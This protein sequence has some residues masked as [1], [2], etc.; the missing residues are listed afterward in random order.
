MHWW[1][2]AAT[3]TYAM[4]AVGNAYAACILRSR[5][6]WCPSAAGFALIA[7]MSAVY[8]AAWGWVAVDPSVDR[9]G[10]SEFITPGSTVFPLVFSL[11]AW[12]L[13]DQRRAHSDSG[14]A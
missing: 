10:W 14:L 11:P 2:A 7:F 4:A 5:R 3:A 6:R 13:I 12:M 8:V 9:G 1:A